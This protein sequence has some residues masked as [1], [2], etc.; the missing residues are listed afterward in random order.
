[1]DE[2][3]IRDYLAERD[4]AEI[5]RLAA[6]LSPRGEDFHAAWLVKAAMELQAA[7]VEAVFQQRVKQ[8]AA[9]NF[10]TLLDLA[11]RLELSHPTAKVSH[12]TTQVSHS[13][14]PE[15]AQT[16]DFFAPLTGPVLRRLQCLVE[17]SSA[18]NEAR[19]TRWTSCRP[20]LP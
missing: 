14:R 19:E 3:A 7:A 17:D 2:S 4:V 5:A 8:A 16:P 10:A 9:M 6:A 13:A 15:I 11:Q 20:G 12:P 1:M 18:A